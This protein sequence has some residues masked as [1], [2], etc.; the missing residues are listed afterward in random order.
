MKKYIIIVLFLPLFGSISLSQINHSITLG[1]DLGI[2]ANFG[3]SSKASIGGSF[4][5]V[6]KFSPLIGIRLAGGYNRFNG[7]TSSFVSFFPIRVGLQAF[8]SD[9]MI[10]FF[11]DGGVADFKA[12]SGTEKSDPSFGIGAGYR[13]PVAGSQFAQFSA[14]F[15]FFRLKVDPPGE[16][17]NYTW[18]NFRAA[19][20]LSFGKK[21]NPKE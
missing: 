7:K 17:I 18:F 11:A 5:Y 12:G 21:N 14:W 1:P 6:A 15:N 16:D 20:G 4:E 19:Y 9:D 3:K 8:V 2:G 10:F 13:L